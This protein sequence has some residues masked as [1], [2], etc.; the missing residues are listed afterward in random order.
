MEQGRLFPILATVSE[1][2]L[3]TAPDW[4]QQTDLA[5]PSSAAN[6]L[7]SRSDSRISVPM[8]KVTLVHLAISLGDGG[9]FMLM[10]LV[11]ETPYNRHIAAFTIDC[12]V[13]M[14]QSAWLSQTQGFPAFQVERGVRS[15][16][17]SRNPN[18]KYWTKPVVSSLVVLVLASFYRRDNG[19]GF[20][21]FTI[22]TFSTQ[23]CRSGS[24]R[25][26]TSNVGLFSCTANAFSVQR[27][28][29]SHFRATS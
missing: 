14:D 7:S 23:Q 5:P 21:H 19:Q 17:I 26:S 3:N 1:V 9:V 13:L 27:M 20:F 15:P 25:E 11:L 6:A 4:F 24:R 18:Q 22:T 28:A 29:I 8:F 2:V 16:A 12:W 10:A